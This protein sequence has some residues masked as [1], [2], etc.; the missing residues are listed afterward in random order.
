MQ[1]DGAA[2][3]FVVPGHV[4]AAQPAPRPTRDLSGS[5]VARPYSALGYSAL[6]KRV[7]FAPSIEASAIKPFS[8][9]TN[10]TTGFCSVS[11]S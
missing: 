2:L 7:S 11:V 1:H 6:G 8:P 9:N 5:R 4:R 3:R 10:A